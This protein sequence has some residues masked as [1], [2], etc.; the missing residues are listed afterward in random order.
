MHSIRTRR[1]VIAVSLAGLLSCHGSTVGELPPDGVGVPPNVSVAV[2]PA[3]ARVGPGGSLAFAAIVAGTVSTAVNWSVRETGGGTV[4]GTGRYTAPTTEGAY[5]LVATSAAV[6]SA[7]GSAL[8]NVATGYALASDRVT[9]W[10]PGVQGGIPNYTNVY[11]TVTAP[12][13]DMATTIQQALDAA[14]TAAAA[15]G[16]GRVIMLRAGTYNVST[17]LVVPSK[18]VLRGAGMDA[19]GKMLSQIYFTGTD[20]NVVR[21]G[22]QWSPAD[23]GSTSLSADGV[24]GSTSVQVANS[25]GFA[26]G[27]YVVIDELTDTNIVWWHPDKHPL[28]TNRDWFNRNNR[29]VQQWIKIASVSG[30]TIT[31]VRALHTNFRT[32]FNAQVTSFV[33]V[34]AGAQTVYAGV[35]DVRVSHCMGTKANIYFNI[36]ENCW[37]KHVDVD[38]STGSAIGF[39][40]SSRCEV[41]DSYVH[42]TAYPEPGGNGYGIDLRRGSS[43]NLI[44]NNISIRFNKV[45]NFRSSGGG[46]VIAYNYMDDGYIN[47]NLGWVETGLQAS[48][49]PCNHYELFEGNYCFNA[50][51]DATEGNA[52]YIT[53]FRNH[54]S[55]HRLG[56]ISGMTDG[57]SVQAAG[58]MTHHWWYNW[59]GNVLGLPGTNYSS[60]IQ[61]QRGPWNAGDEAIWRFGTWDQDYSVND[62]S[63]YA[64]AYRDGNFDYKSNG[65][66]WNGLGGAGSP[67]AKSLPDSLYLLGK[68]AFFGSNTWPWV[69]PLGTTKISTLPAKARYDAG[70][71]NG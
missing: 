18:V 5:H 4:D 3:Q 2:N 20:G 60:W 40:L 51:A 68:P 66:A 49:Y 42:D 69:D 50:A 21:F 67:P 12:S 15:D 41:R 37:A 6:P 45:I 10:S 17:E 19:S 36:A 35:E 47:S 28:G 62:G 43:D 64:T 1:T 46:N 48:H 31:F 56:S 58:A 57:G 23:A 26:A 25:A 61:D 38:N 27:M 59:I 7:S 8:V 55:G 70:R 71:P 24:K 52:I 63:V 34:G 54:L 33:G 11:S 44:E 65:V 30:N 13:G 9:D 53:F 16:I 32:A 39:E 14:G 29:P 22:Q